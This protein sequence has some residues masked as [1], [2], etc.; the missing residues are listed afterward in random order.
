MFMAKVPFLL[1][2]TAYES[3]AGSILLTT[4]NWVVKSS[5]MLSEGKYNSYIL[6]LIKNCNVFKSGGMR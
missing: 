2:G 5:I 3:W 6:F 4:I 1:Q